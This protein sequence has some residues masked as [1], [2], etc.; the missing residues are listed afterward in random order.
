MYLNDSIL[1]YA[2]YL[3]KKLVDIKGELQCLAGAL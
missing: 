1:F 3:L 2:V